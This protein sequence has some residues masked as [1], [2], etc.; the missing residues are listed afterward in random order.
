MVLFMKCVPWFLIK[1]L[2]HP[3]LV[4]TYSNEK[5]V[6]VSALQYFTGATSAHLVRYSIAVIMYLSIILLVGGLIGPTK[7]IAPLSNSLN[8]TCGLSGISSLLLGL[9][10][11]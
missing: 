8:V 3:N 1:T 11:L 9:P 6:A 4:I 7:S 5:C 10:T 2:G